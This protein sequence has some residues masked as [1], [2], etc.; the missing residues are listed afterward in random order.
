M[1]ASEA[2]LSHSLTPAT[3][4]SHFI[5]NLTRGDIS[6]V[7]YDGNSINIT[8]NFPEQKSDRASSWESMF[9]VR[10]NNRF[11]ELS[12]KKDEVFYSLVVQVPHQTQLTLR[13]LDAKQ[14]SIAGLESNVEISAKTGKLRVSDIKGSVV[15][16]VSNGRIVA[17]LT[18]FKREN[19]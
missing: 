8:A 15:A 13:A 10:Q 18:H 2:D 6:I 11:I 1:T 14:L 5:V 12:T 16:T 9:N 19:I 3:S 17:N 4:T 7:G